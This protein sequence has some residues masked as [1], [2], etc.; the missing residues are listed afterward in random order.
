MIKKTILITG[1]LLSTTSSQAFDFGGFLDNIKE[2][3]PALTQAAEPS[4]TDQASP[5]VSTTSEET[6]AQGL[7]AALSQGVE[8][9]VKEL[10]QEGGYLN[11]PSVKIPLPSALAKTESM[12]RSAGGDKIA[13]D[14]INSMNLA[15]AKSAIKAAPI[16][17]KSIKDM[18]IEDAKKILLDG[19]SS[20]TDYFKK[21]TMDDLKSTMKPIVQET[22]KDNN[23]AT[24]HD[25][26]NGY[27]SSGMK[28]V[29]ENETIMGYAKSFGVEQFIPEASDE[30][31]DDYVTRS[32]IDGLFKMI[33]QKET[34]IRENPVSQTTSLLQKVFAK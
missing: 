2:S 27:Y 7:K 8:Y 28:M 18:S 29:K 22:M 9:G 26:F 15:A 12:I 23:V 24:Y 6:V 31:L 32:A 10:S 4:S 34:Q 11:N 17:M 13:D 25:T 3:V 33:A 16:F 5:S 21:H 30:K 1:L 14:L 19:G 20:A